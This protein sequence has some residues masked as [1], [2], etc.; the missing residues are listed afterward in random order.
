MAVRELAQSLMQREVALHVLALSDA[1]SVVD[2]GTWSPVEPECHSGLPW[3][4]SPGLSNALAATSQDVLHQHGI[5]QLWSRDV[6]R[7]GRQT[8]KPVVISPH[9]MLDPWALR[10][11]SWKK[12]L[13]MTLYE[14]QN[15]RSAAC[16][17]ALNESEANS[18]GALGLTN[19]IAVIPNG[20]ALP[21]GRGHPR[22]AFLSGDDRKVLLFL[23]RIHPKKGVCETLEAWAE[24]LH[25]RPQLGREWCL[26][27][28][29]W[30]DGNYLKA[31]RARV[32]ALGLN[33]HAHFAG[34][35]FG[36][37]K[38]ACL[39]NASA[40]ILASHSEGLPMAVLE[41]WAYRLPVFMTKACN[42]PEGFMVGGAIEISARPVAL[43]KA[44]LERLDD[45]ALAQ[46][47]QAGRLLVEQ[48]FT[49]DR[50]ADE[51]LSVYNWQLSGGTAPNCVM[52]SSPQ[53]S[54]PM[55]GN[56]N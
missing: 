48:R 43:A 36:D 25:Q 39:A 20:V 53:A 42:L 19:P 15:L 45:P 5:W 28:A 46:V 8:S 40:F 10:N 6:L 17:H 30:D 14:G 31:L 7:W 47:G 38:A 54:R 2:R 21:D 34:P 16:L 24:V 55:F 9:G 56:I 13:A 44:L 32:A 50:V 1:R 12:Q 41:A 3:G 11:S 33:G 26:V 51:M 52:R 23:G 49:W 29:G 18:F 35:L 27:V 4:F 37:G 22:P